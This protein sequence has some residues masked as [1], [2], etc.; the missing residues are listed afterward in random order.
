MG[1]NFYIF[2]WGVENFNFI[3]EEKILLFF[4]KFLGSISQKSLFCPFCA[5][6]SVQKNTQENFSYPL[7][8]HI[9]FI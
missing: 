6:L 5:L 2:L 9:Q 7:K 4:A 8:I 3:L 1:F